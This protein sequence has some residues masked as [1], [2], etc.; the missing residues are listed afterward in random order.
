MFLLNYVGVGYYENNDDGQTDHLVVYHM[1]NTTWCA[2]KN[3]TLTGC[4]QRV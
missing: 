4:A 3:H 1:P 2:H